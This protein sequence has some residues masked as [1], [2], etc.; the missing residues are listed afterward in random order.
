[1]VII[2]AE[3]SSDARNLCKV[4]ALA[5]A[6]PGRPV[7][8]RI[9]QNKTLIRISDGWLHNYWDSPSHS[10][11][12]CRGD[13]IAVIV[14]PDEQESSVYN[15]EFSGE[16]AV[17]TMEMI[18]KYVSITYENKACQ[19]LNQSVHIAML[20]VHTERSPWNA[21]SMWEGRC[22]ASCVFDKFKIADQAYDMPL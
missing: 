10:R 11:S 18:R 17:K 7:W 3:S 12:L 8:P 20:F 2:T 16:N 14:T 21:H 19:S 22:Y 1:M 9:Q 13:D 6:L 5:V 15:I 4:A